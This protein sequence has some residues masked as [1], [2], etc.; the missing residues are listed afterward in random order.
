MVVHA[1]S[2]AGTDWLDRADGMLGP[3]KTV[4]L[5]AG[6]LR[7]RERGQGRTLLFLHGLLVNGLLWRRVV[8]LLADRFRCV[9]PDLPLGSHVLPLNVDADRSLFGLAALVAEFMEVLHLDDVIVI[10]NDSGGAV[11]QALAIRHARRISGMVLTPSDC[12]ENFLPPLFRYLQIGSRFPGFIWLAAQLLR[13]KPFRRLP[14][15]FGWL[16][17]RPVP[18]ELLD[19]YLEPT[20]KDASI[21]ADVQGVLRAISNRDTLA[22]AQEFPGCGK[23]VLLAWS[24]EDRIFTWRYAEKLAQDFPNAR[25]VAID[26]AYTFVPEE[27]PEQLANLIADFA[28]PPP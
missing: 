27:R 16:S 19:V 11:S 9:T 1:R 21:R 13:V 23:P 2:Q 26:D 12:Y 24:K 6:T 14:L 7:F 5:S 18:H 25:L 10:G 3:A 17:K 28:A 20:L 8:D 4:Q 15:A 22:L